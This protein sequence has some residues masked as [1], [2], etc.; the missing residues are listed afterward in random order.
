M[1]VMHI[2]LAK[3]MGN[4]ITTAILIESRTE[5]NSMNSKH[6]STASRAGMRAQDIQRKAPWNPSDWNMLQ[7]NS[8]KTTNWEKNNNGVE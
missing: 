6:D 4:G 7:T 5:T 3:R 8:R 1:F 2:C